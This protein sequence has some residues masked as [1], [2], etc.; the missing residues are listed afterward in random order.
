MM[1]AAAAV[2]CARPVTILGAECVRKSYPNFWD[3]YARLG[4]QIEREE[5]EP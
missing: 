5:S 1:A 3:D 2:R 4:G